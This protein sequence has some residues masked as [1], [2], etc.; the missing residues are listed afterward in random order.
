MT[1]CYIRTSDLWIMGMKSRS[2]YEIAQMLYGYCF[3]VI[4][5]KLDRL[6]KLSR[7]TFL[8]LKGSF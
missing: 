5:L 3:Y 1:D 7:Y 2:T 8:F 4:P 6:R